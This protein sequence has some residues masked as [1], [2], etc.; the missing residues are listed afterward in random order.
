MNVVMQHRYPHSDPSPPPRHPSDDLRQALA[1]ANAVFDQAP[2][3][4]LREILTAYRT[5]G[6]GDRDMLL[7]MLKAKTS[8]DQRISSLASLQR[9]IIE[10]HQRTNGAE[11]L[12][13]PGRSAAGNSYPYSPNHTPGA[14]SYPADQRPSRRGGNTHRAS[15]RSRSPARAHPHMPPP[16]DAPNPHQEPHPRK[17][18]RSS[19]S[20][21]PHHRGAYE[22]SHP[23]E[24]FPPSPYSSDRS[25][26]AD[27]SP[28]SKASM[29]IGSL[30]SVGPRREPNGEAALQ[31]R[32]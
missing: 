15:S 16:R 26:S 27:Y 18:H 11:V 13:P 10:L 23:A 22:P 24:Q 9:T 5:K 14:P 4:S 1:S 12:S 6:D 21:P 7:A 3:P 30:L 28:R 25:E 8:E 20:P 17:R 2:P 19:R 32:E 29:N 31:D